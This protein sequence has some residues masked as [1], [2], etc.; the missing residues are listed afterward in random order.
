TSYPLNYTY[1]TIIVDIII[2]IINI[3]N[4]NLYIYFN[5]VLY[6]ISRYI[7]PPSN[8]ILVGATNI[9]KPYIDCVKKPITGYTAVSVT[10]VLINGAILKIYSW[11]S[12]INTL[13][14]EVVVINLNILNL[15][16]PF[17]VSLLSIIA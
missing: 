9:T 6:G 12:T 3:C 11:R 8:N 10:T 14:I 1:S 15:A 4:S 5:H 17:E 16:L 2:M 13:P 7:S